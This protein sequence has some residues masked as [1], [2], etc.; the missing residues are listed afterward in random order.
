MT[1][2]NFTIGY[3][4]KETG[5][6][7][8]TIRYYE[9][10]GILPVPE[11]TAGNQRRYGPR[12]VQQLTFIRH[13]RQLGFPLE[14]IRQMMSLADNP[15]QSCGTVDQIARTQLLEVQSRI[16]RLQSLKVELIRMVEQ[17]R[18]GQVADCRVLEV[19]SDHA[20]CLHENHLGS[21]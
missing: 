6:K 7:I 15:D 12:H 13:S 3:L 17:C 16:E 20:H 18:G 1:T 5:C 2:N 4:A 11:R 14:S 21:E 9:Q 8:Q 10:I 19:L